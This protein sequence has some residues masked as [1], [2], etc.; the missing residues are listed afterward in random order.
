[1]DL[2]A[3]YQNYA[4]MQNN[5]GDNLYHIYLSNKYFLMAAQEQMITVYLEYLLLDFYSLLN[6]K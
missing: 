5:L 4:N 3:T 2:L 6:Y 1:M